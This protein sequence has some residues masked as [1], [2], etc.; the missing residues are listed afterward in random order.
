MTAPSSRAQNKPNAFV[1]LGMHKSGTTLVSECLHKAGI[2]MEEGIAE[3]KG[4]EHGYTLERRA[5][6]AVNK[7]YLN[8]GDDQSQ[9]ILLSQDAVDPAIHAECVTQAAALI[10]DLSA[11]GHPWGFK[12]PRTLLVMPVWEQAFERTHI[13]PC[14][15]GVYRNPREVFGHYKRLLKRKWLHHDPRYLVRVL[16]SWSAHNRALLEVAKRN[17]DLALFEFTALMTQDIEIGRLY[18]LIGTSGPD[19]RKSDLYRARPGADRNYQ[20]ARALARLSGSEDPEP[21][22]AE[23]NNRRAR[24]IDQIGQIAQKALP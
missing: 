16:Q 22:M 2:P 9:D 8:C 24:Q 4:Y 10:D 13:R 12:D 1:V 7:R 23:L 3:P 5:A 17:P 6:Q 19:A 15:I 11:Q 18:E 20:I 14:L 21:L